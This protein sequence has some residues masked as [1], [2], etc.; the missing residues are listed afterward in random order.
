[1]GAEAYCAERGY[2]LLLV[3]SFRYEANIDWKELPLPQALRRESSVRAVILAGTNSPSL[4]TL[5][6]KKGI[7]F[8]VLGNNVIGEWEP[9]NYNVVWYDDLHGASEVTHYL[10]SLGH[11][12]IWFV[13]NQQLPWYS[14]CAEGYRRAMKEANLLPRFRNIRS[15]D[16]QEV[17]YLSTKSILRQGEPISAIFAGSAEAGPGVYKALSEFGRSVPQ[18][19]SIVGVGELEAKLLKPELTSFRVFP[20]QLGEHLAEM[21]IGRI[22]RPGLPARQ[23]T[24]PTEVVKRESCRPVD[25]RVEA[26]V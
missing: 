14:R 23:V 20:E 7:P 17:G 2:D 24:I 11:N 6:N 21:A 8:A 26:Q 13:G 10:I 1:V 15:G 12:H 18:D 4:L 16:G 5:L 19:V 25:V 9:E 22:N 3:L